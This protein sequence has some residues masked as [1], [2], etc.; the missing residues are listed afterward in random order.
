MKRRSFFK[1]AAAV[2]V[3]AALPCIPEAPPPNCSLLIIQEIE[4]ELDRAYYAFA[5][6]MGALLYGA[7]P[8]HSTY[9]VSCKPVSLLPERP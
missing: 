4:R 6:Q 2:A 8:F 1:A 9:L 5:R 7:E 3:S